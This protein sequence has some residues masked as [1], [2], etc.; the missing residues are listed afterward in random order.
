MGDKRYQYDV[1]LDNKIF[2]TR[3]CSVKEFNT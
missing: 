2:A 3:Y 1:I